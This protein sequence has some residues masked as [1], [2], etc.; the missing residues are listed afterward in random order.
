MAADGVNN[1]ALVSPGPTASIH[2]TISPAAC[3]GN[4]LFVMGIGDER[5]LLELATMLL[6]L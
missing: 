5:H 4:V 6:C 2:S 3:S 1:Q